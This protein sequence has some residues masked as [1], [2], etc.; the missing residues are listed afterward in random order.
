MAAT[1]EKAKKP[2]AAKASPAKK[3]D[4]KAVSPAKPKK[5]K[6]AKASVVQKSP[7]HEQ[8]VDT[9]ATAEMAES[10]VAE[11]DFDADDISLSVE[12]DIDAGL[13]GADVL[14][15]LGHDLDDGDEIGRAHV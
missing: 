3:A 1:K 8:V 4:K 15:D 7:E 9:G 6:S 2:A 11:L 5:K 13:H 12:A 10:A 14:D